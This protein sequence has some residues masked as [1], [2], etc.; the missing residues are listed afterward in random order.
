[1][2]FNWKLPSFLNFNCSSGV[3]FKSWS[4][5]S[6]K[7]SIRLSSGSFSWFFPKIHVWTLGRI[8]HIFSGNFQENLL[9]SPS[10]NLPENL[11][12]FTPAIVYGNSFESFHQKFLRE[13]FLE[14]HRKFLQNSFRSFTR[15]SSGHCFT[16][17]TR[18]SCSSS[19]VFTGSYH[20]S[21]FGN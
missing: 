7:R 20:N 16:S 1:M 21:F 12:A 15:G 2:R 17:P 13:F 3:F 6:F 18:K 9:C 4:W 5:N 14:L 19:G 11:P 10:K 8:V